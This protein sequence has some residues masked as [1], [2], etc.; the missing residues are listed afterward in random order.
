[1]LKVT[2]FAHNQFAELQT[3]WTALQSGPEMT[4]FQS[5]QWFELVNEHFSRER[6]SR[7]VV[8]AVYYL[9]SDEQDTPV[10]IA[11]LRVHLLRLSPHHR[12]G[13]HLLGRNGYADYLN[14]IY[15]EFDPA[16]ASMVVDRAVADFGLRQFLMERITAGTSSYAWFASHIGA[17]VEDQEAV[18]VQLPSSLEEYNRMLSKSTRQN[19]RTAWNR[20]R[21]DGV[22]LRVN[23]GEAQI[24]EDVAGQLALLKRQREENRARRHLRL[25]QRVRDLAREIVFKALFTEFNEAHEAMKRMADPWVLLVRARGE[26]CAFAFGLPDGFG[27]RRVLRVLQ[28]AYDESYARYSPGLI[29]LHAF[30]SDEIAQHLPNFDVI[31]FTRGGERYKHELGG[32]RTVLADVSFNVAPSTGSSRLYADPVA[33]FAR[34]SS[35]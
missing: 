6:L 23:W 28:V 26:I 9:V 29:G 21:K 22:S 27:G 12:R 31:D 14:F 35:D 25:T 33:K 24:D 18:Q 8:R 1:M 3:H 2:R 17:K 10:L 16:A 7:A 20:S 19:V 5:F 32:T 34:G 15:R 4:V 30:L 11:P 13:V